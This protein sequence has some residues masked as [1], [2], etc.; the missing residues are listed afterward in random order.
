MSESN[1]S[2]TNVALS[3]VLLVVGLA[4]GF[5]VS[6]ATTE[7]ETKSNSTSNSSTATAG[8]SVKAADLRANL[9]SLG[10]QHMDLTYAAVD[11]K[12]AGTK[13]ADAVGADLYKN[14][15]NIGAAVGSVYGQ[16][17]ETTFNS[18][19]KLH[20]DQF[21]TYAIAASKADEAGKA[22]ALAKIEAEYTK[23]L[24]AYLAKANPNLPEDVLFTTLDEHVKQTAAMIDQQ[25]AGDYAG[26]AIAR[27]QAAQHLVGVFSTLAGGI[28]KQYPEKFQD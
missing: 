24:A 19:W 22:A 4:V 1:K 28:V 14:G 6:K 9:V 21:V 3:A 15:E 26:A 17:A 23:P 8:T 27:E 20:L 18:V 11:A 12:L 2:A 5:G 25:A 7:N 10:V 16:E 13:S